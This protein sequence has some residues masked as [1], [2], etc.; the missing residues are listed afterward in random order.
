MAD[1]KYNPQKRY[2]QKHMKTITLKYKTEYVDEFKESLKILGLKQSDVFR[3]RMNEIIYEAR[4][5]K[6]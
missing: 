5:K 3:E 6:S 1:P 2:Q 4:N